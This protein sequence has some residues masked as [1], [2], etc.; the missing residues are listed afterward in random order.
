M[1][2]SFG[3]LVALSIIL[4]VVQ[5]AAALPWL[6]AIELRMRQRL[7][8]PAFW[9]MA[10]LACAA[11]GLVGGWYLDANSDRQ[12]LSNVG[13]VY[14]SLLHLQLATDFFVAFFALALTFWPKGGAVALSA[15]R[16]GIRQPMF[17]LITGLF[18]LFMFISVI[19]PYF[20]F[21]ED[22][23]MVVELC[24]AATMLAAGLFGVLEAS[25]SVSDEI[26]GR[27]A[28]TVMSKPVSRRQFL[29]GKFGGI[30]LSGLFMTVI[31]G[32]FLVW[33]VLL[34]AWYTRM[35]TEQP[36]PDPIWV[37]ELSNQL[38]P[39][40]S[41]KDLMLGM[42]LWTADALGALPQLSIGFCQVM[43][44][45]AIAVALAT[46]VPMVINLLVCITVYFLGHLTPI[47]TEVSRAGDRVANRLVY[48]V[49]Q[50]FD[51]VLPGLDHFDVGTAIVREAPVAPV[52]YA[53]YTANVVLY[54]ITYTA[55]ALLF[56]LIL[57]EDRDLA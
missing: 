1:T 15:F 53:I 39:A 23:K 7:R 16:E 54:A 24:F 52:D 9:G 26:E 56:G 37:V 10:L 49:A 25:M 5:F 18:L 3:S 13:R 43:V 51:T 19:I 48:F 14:M 17:W 38:Y 22:I 55:I 35:P 11:V 41:A 33:F 40:S 50:V 30:L 47:M 8:R 27:T 4:C 2:P 28:I 29:L 57:F 20:T 46:R 44:L 45:V 42:G 36:A 34:G 32:W 12:V 6:M 31:L 21:G